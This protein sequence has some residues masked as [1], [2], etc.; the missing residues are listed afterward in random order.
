[1]LLPSRSLATTTTTSSPGPSPQAPLRHLTQHTIQHR[2]ADLPDGPP[3]NSSSSSSS[4]FIF[5][6]N[7]NPHRQPRPSERLLIHPSPPPLTS[8]QP[9]LDPHPPLPWYLIVTTRLNP[10]VL[11]KVVGAP[12]VCWSPCTPLRCMAVLRGYWSLCNHTYIY[13]HFSVM[14]VPRV[15]WGPCNT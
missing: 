5:S 7:Y 2:P 9:G 4:P 15:C 11:F 3:S 1:M 8:P 14:A 13:N 10:H 6:H 12:R